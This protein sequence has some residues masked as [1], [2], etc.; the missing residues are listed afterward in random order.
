MTYQ[1][2]TDSGWPSI[3][4]ILQKQF[5][6]F[7]L[8]G[9]QILAGFET[10]TSYFKKLRIIK[11]FYES[12]MPEIM[13]S[14]RRIVANYFVDWPTFFTPIEMDAWCS[15]RYRGIP[16]YPQFPVLTYHCDFANPHLK[17]IIELD[18]K[19][20]HVFEK[21]FARDKELRASGWTVYRITGSEMVKQASDLEEYETW[22]LEDEGIRSDIRQWIIGTG[23]GV[24][25]AIREIYFK[26]HVPGDDF[27][28][29]YHEICRSSLELHKYL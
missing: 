27:G 13:A 14:P 6:Q 29:W 21:D 16:F 2:K 22:Q 5:P 1:E 18:G 9:N 17:I 10:E 24:I 15:L 4:D 19:D 7:N 12:I 8:G 3:G 28:D 23:D 20:F 26:D 11:A 25:E